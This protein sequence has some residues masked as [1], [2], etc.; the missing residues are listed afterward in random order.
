MTDAKSIRSAGSLGSNSSAKEL[1]S[2]EFFQFKTITIEIVSM[3]DIQSYHRKELAK[4]RLSYANEFYET[5]MK[6]YEWGE[7]FTI[8]LVE[9][10][11]EI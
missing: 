10:Y 3:E 7:S 5:S 1:T 6:K 9:D 4:I 8:D 2:E 11:T